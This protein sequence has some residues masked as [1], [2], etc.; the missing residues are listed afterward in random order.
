[1]KKLKQKKQNKHKSNSFRIALTSFIAALVFL[2]LGVIE[3]ITIG[4]KTFK[5][6]LIDASILFAL[7]TPCLGTYA[8]RRFTDAKYLGKD[9]NGDIIRKN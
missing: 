2:G 5:F 4:D 6:R 1:M 9:S 8:V 3:E 7:L